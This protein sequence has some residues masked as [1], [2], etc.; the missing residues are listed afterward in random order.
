MKASCAVFLFALVRS[1]G[2]EKKK[3]RAASQT[4][5]RYSSG[6]LCSSSF[7][8]NKHLTSNPETPHT[9]PKIY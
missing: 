1:E 6:V 5:A 4:V 7:P 9:S 8:P 2:W 3:E